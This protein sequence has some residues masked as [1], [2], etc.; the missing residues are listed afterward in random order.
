MTILYDMCQGFGEFRQNEHFSVQECPAAD[1]MSVILLL[2][3]SMLFVKVG[4]AW[5]NQDGKPCG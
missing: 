3:I 2:V 4:L 5:N 1:T